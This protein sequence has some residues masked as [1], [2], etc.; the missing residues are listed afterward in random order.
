MDAI[1]GF[2]IA[3]LPYPLVFK[4]AA[5]P[6]PLDDSMNFNVILLS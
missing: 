3:K 6:P 4:S 1:F 2:S 5:P